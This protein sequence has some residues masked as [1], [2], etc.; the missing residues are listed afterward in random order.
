MG[1]VQS[2]AGEVP[3][4]S[5][6]A[7]TYLLQ[8]LVV[9]GRLLI[10]PWPLRVYYSPHELGITWVSVVAVFALAA[11]FALAVSRGRKKTALFAAVWIILFLL[12]V[13]MPDQRGGALLAERFLYLPSV[14]LCLL[15]GAISETWR[16][17]RRVLAGGLGIIVALM[18]VGTTHQNRAWKDEITLFEEFTRVSPL[19]PQ[20][21]YNLGNALA[22]QGRHLEAVNEFNRAIRM[23]P[24]HYKALFN[25]GNSFRALDR[26]TEAAGCYRTVLRIRPDMVPAWINLGLALMK[27]GKTGESIEAYRE[28]LGFDPDSIRLHAGLMLAYLEAGDTAAAREHL[29][30]LERKNP[31]MASLLSGLIAGNLEEKGDVGAD[32]PELRGP[33]VENGQDR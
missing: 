7:I 27:E 19:S 31:R 11:L 16:G 2:G 23:D 30:L 9:Y 18:A 5:S 32:P 28:G 17:N 13:L 22:D 1:L 25:M 8:I 12:P 20:G 15:A 26:N 14:G 21:Y 29:R 10:L 6:L 24:N 33:A 4:G 3:P